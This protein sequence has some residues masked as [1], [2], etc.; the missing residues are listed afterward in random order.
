M[1]EK[2][3]DFFITDGRFG[4]FVFKSCQNTYISVKE[5]E[6]LIIESLELYRENRDYAIRRIE[7]ADK[8]LNK[9]A[10][11]RGELSPVIIKHKKRIA[12][13]KALIKGGADI[14][15]CDGNFAI[16]N[17]E[18]MIS[19]ANRSWKRLSKEEWFKMEN[20][21]KELKALIEDLNNVDREQV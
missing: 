3:Y 11:I 4:K 5:M 9:I 20:V 13:I 1:Y 8:M 16:L 21:R 18:V 12:T 14:T 17:D 6:A 15:A 7:E 2:D 19:L 10:N